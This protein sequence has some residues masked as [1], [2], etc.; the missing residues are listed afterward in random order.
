MLGMLAA[1]VW[2]WWIGVGLSA[3]LI[4]TVVGLGAN[5]LKSVSATRYP[6]KRHH[7]EG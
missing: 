1:N 5:Y 3:L 2:H 7:G 6:G 4:L